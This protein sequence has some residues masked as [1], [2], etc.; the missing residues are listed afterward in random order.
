VV[1]LVVVLLL[2]LLLQSQSQLGDRGPA[3]ADPAHTKHQRSA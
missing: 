2:L 3:S 1:L